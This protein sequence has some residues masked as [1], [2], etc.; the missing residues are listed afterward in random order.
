MRSVRIATAAMIDLHD[1]W[2]YV[3]QRDAEAASRLIKEIV[4]RFRFLRDN[5]RMGRQQDQLLINLRSLSFK[6]Y[7]IFYQ[8]FAEHIDI[9]R[10]LHGSRDVESIFAQFFDAL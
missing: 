5:P 8:P 3:A 4:R 2:L 1:I 6:D 9:L 10:V 7:L